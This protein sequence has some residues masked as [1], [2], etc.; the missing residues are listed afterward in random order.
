VGDYVEQGDIYLRPLVVRAAMR[1]QLF[2]QTERLGGWVPQGNPALMGQL[3]LV[4]PESSLVLRMLKERRKTYPGGVPVAGHNAARR[5]YWTQDTLGDLVGDQAGAQPAEL[6]LLWDL[7]STDQASL[8]FTL[9]VVRTLEPGRYG[10]AVPIDLSIDI[11]ARGGAWE[12]LT[13]PRSDEHEDFF[14]VRLDERTGETVQQ[15]P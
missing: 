7:A 15:G 3:H 2:D 1:A 10:A 12:Q 6:L 4:H 14:A 5:Q 9:R 13:F 8:A 11:D